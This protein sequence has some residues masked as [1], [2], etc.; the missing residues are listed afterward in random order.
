MIMFHN[1]NIRMQNI[2]KVYELKVYWDDD[3][4]ELIHKKCHYKSYRNDTKK[5]I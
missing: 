5:Y 3:M 2:P 1:I 4:C